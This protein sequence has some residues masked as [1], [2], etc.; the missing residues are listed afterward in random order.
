MK[1]FLPDY[2]NY[3][4]ETTKENDIASK[5]YKQQMLNF[6]EIDNYDWDKIDVVMKELFKDIE[7]DPI[8]RTHL[9]KYKE[10][11]FLENLEMTLV[12]MFS[13]DHFDTFM[14]LLIKNK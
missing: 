12:Y 11:Y 8:I 7:H 14:E 13:Y 3:E 1:L 6:F 5:K 2:K 9:E 4:K 10:I